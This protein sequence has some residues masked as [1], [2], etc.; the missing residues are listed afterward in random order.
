MSEF[1]DD[2]IEPDRC[3]KYIPESNSY[4][5]LEPEHQGRCEPLIYHYL[6]ESKEKS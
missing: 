5:C 2:S 3:G 1:Y 4:C 6:I